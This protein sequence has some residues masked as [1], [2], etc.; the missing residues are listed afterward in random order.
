VALP[1][2][3][4]LR[5][6]LCAPLWKLTPRGIQ[7]ESKEDRITESGIKESGIKSRLGRSPDK[8]EAVVYCSINTPKKHPNNDNWRNRVRKGSWRI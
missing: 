2:D 4:E 7:I 3:P 1:P 8:G 6:D 5:A